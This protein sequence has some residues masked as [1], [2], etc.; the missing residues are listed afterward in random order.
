VSVP[1][2]AKYGILIWWVSVVEQ[3]NE[4]QHLMQAIEEIKYVF[5]CF[6]RLAL[7]NPVT[8]GQDPE[9]TATRA[10]SRTQES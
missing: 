1:G 6:Q 4:N 8:Q 9:R 3:E 7:T 2:I 10:R 5:F